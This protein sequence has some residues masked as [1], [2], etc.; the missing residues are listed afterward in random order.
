M[1]SNYLVDE[2]KEH[3]YKV[4]DKE[5]KWKNK[6]EFDDDRDK[7]KTSLLPPIKKRCRFAARERPSSQRQIKRR[8][9]SPS[10]RDEAVDNQGGCEMCISCSR[11]EWSSNILQVPQL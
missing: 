5:A 11:S 8:H 2:E 3:G 4:R 9:C 1:E 10:Y 7:S 6:E